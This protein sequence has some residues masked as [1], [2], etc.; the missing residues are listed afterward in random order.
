VLKFIRLGDS[1][2][3]ELL[4]DP[5]ELLLDRETDRLDIEDRE[6]CEPLLELLRELCLPPELLEDD[7]DDDDL[8]LLLDAKTGSAKITAPS[9]IISTNFRLNP[10]FFMIK[11]RITFKFNNISL[12]AC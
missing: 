5:R 11:S 8:L 1:I 6:D 3:L 10:D 9:I 12:I 4:L 2:L 7:L